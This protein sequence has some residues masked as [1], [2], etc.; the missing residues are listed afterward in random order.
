MALKAV[1]FAAGYGKRLRPLT[2]NRPKHVLPIAGK[3]LVKIIVESLAEA[4]VSDVGVLIGYHG[5]FVRKSLTGVKQPRLDFIIQQQLLGTGAALKECRQ[6]LEGEE[7]FFVVYGDV[8][9]TADVLRKLRKEMEQERYDGM[10]AAVKT[11]E[12][13]RFGIVETQ[14]NKLIK[15][16]EKENKPGPVNAGIYIL[17]REIFPILET[18]GFSP[19]GEIELT[20]AV[21]KYVEGGK[22]VG[23]EVFEGNWWFD[24]GNP[25][26]YLNANRFFIQKIHGGKIVME[27]CVTIGDGC[28]LKGAVFL[29][30][31]VTFGKNCK[32]V[33]PTMIMA[34]SK[35][36]TGSLV[37]ESVVLENCYV[38][39]NSYLKNSIICENNVFQQGVEVVSEGLPAFVS[40]PGALY[41]QRLK[42][43]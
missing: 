34:G 22:V 21:N 27:P 18:I 39:K 23:V 13:A 31:S 29:G 30:E 17:S 36:D 24:V 32:I 3:P 14:N 5:E 33:G 41:K 42:V 7:F 35:I 6:Y 1:V 28:V 2:V 16:R 43:V 19:R 9:V 10:L 20:D 37:S 38:G 40:E 12:T 8:T 26:D 11:T 4:G 25:S 15:I